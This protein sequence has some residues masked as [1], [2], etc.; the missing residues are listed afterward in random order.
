MG[1]QPWCRINP[2]II[3]AFGLLARD[4]H[5]GSSGA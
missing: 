4:R 2:V 3:W 5:V 1:N